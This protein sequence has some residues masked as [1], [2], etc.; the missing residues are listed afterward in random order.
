MALESQ[1]TNVLQVGG[2]LSELGI[3][4]G[5]VKYIAVNFKNSTVRKTPTLFAIIF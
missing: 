1:L 5:V 4:S 3:K 2:S